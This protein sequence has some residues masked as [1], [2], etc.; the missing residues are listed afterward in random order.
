M[1]G[2]CTD[3]KGTYCMHKIIV[4]GWGCYSIV[5]QPNSTD[6]IMTIN[7]VVIVKSETSNEKTWLQVTQVFLRV[8]KHSIP[9]IM[10]QWNNY[11]PDL[12]FWLPG[13]TCWNTT[14][15]WAFT[16]Q[17]WFGGAETGHAQVL[18]LHATFCCAALEGKA[19]QSGGLATGCPCRTRV[20]TGPANWV[21][22]TWRA[23]RKWWSRGSRSRIAKKQ[24]SCTIAR[25]KKIPFDYYLPI[26]IVCFKKSWWSGI[27][28]LLVSCSF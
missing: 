2:A 25:G 16:E 18:S 8:D 27:A 9:D 20:A 21:Q 26:C 11:G 17:C 24:G 19:G 22:Q 13:A 28:R 7:N 3:V 14:T 4:H 23:R 12:E 15:C 1:D 6:Q 5:F 10:F